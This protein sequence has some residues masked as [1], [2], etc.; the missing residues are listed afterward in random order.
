M[1]RFAKAFFITAAVLT[2]GMMVWAV[3]LEFI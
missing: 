2:G 3:V 1:L